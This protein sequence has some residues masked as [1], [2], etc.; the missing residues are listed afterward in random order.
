WRAHADAEV[1]PAARPVDVTLEEPGVDLARVLAGAN[2]RQQQ[3]EQGVLAP[4]G[5]E[6]LERPPVLEPRRAGGRRGLPRR[7][8]PPPAGG[9]LGRVVWV[10]A[11]RQ[12]G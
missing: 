4:L 12:P 6:Q 11:R 7:S 5:P 9:G 3:R 2:G 8:D 10:R 1:V